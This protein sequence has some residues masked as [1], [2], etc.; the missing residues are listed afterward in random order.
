MVSYPEHGDDPSTLLRHAELAM[1]A[2]K[3]TH[4]GCTAYS[5]DQDEQARERL[6]LIGALR[7]ALERDEMVLYYQ[8]KIDCRSRQVVGVE[9]LMRWRHPR[10]GLVGPDRF[11]P[12]AEESGLIRELTRWALDAAL[13]QYR[14]WLDNGLDLPLSVNLS[15]LDAQD[16]D[17]P[18]AVANR[19][20]AWR[21][22]PTSLTLELTEGA[23]LA[24]P[25]RAFDVIQRLT[26]LGVHVSL[27]DFGTGYSSLGYLK[28]FRVHELKI[29]RLLVGDIVHEPRDRAI[30]RATVQLGHNLGM[31]VV[32]E[33]VE[34]AATLDLVQ[35]L[36][37]DQAQGYYVGRPM[38][39]ADIQH[40]LHP[41]V[42][43][44]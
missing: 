4:G 11:I 44:A 40:L 3:G 38:S 26:G 19:L 35:A 20:A 14:A 18:E 39:A 42:A 27:D 25:S 6:A 30:V 41:S 15:A 23:L 22:P 12:L 29:D 28:R 24:E 5:A 21:V 32:A 17:L 2:A 9:G 10:L 43:A 1:Y 16:V 37:C 34:D 33:G 8:P 13:S 36:G 31:I 7:G